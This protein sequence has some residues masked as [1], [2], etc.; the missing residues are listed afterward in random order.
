MSRE[1]KPL[2]ILALK[3]NGFK[4]GRNPLHHAWKFNTRNVKEHL[5]SW[6][7]ICANAWASPRYSSGVLVNLG[8]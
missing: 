3:Y 6:R 1:G 4:V 8:S 2:F 5:S 7:E